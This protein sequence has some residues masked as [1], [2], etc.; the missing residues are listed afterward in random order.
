M[1]QCVSAMQST[2]QSSVKRAP[3][4]FGH[5]DQVADPLP[6][7]KTEQSLTRYDGGSEIDAMRDDLKERKEEPTEEQSRLFEDEAE[8]AA[9][10]RP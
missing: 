4:R 3:Q 6:F 8:K 7:S 2:C 5:L 9:W 10:S 1:K